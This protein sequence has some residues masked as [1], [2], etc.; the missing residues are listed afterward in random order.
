MIDLASVYID[1]VYDRVAYTV[2]WIGFATPNSLNQN[3]ELVEQPFTLECQDAFSTL[4]YRKTGIDYINGVSS[5][6]SII[7]N[8]LNNLGT[9]KNL[10]ITSSLRVPDVINTTFLRRIIFNENNLY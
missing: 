9:Y 1:K 10:Y 5:V 2:E 3:Y 6:L 4:K 7:R 8:L